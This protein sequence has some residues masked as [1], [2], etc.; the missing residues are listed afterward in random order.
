MMERLLNNKKGIALLIL[1][2]V[3]I[4]VIAISGSLAY[5][6][7]KDEVVNTF[8]MGKVQID[9]DE[10]GWNE[11]SG[12]NLL[13]GN[14]RVKDPIV[15]ALEGQ[16]YMRIRMEIVDG[17]GNLITDEN[18][19]NMILDTLYYDEAYGTEKA[20]IQNDKR[21][22]VAD[23]TALDNANKINKEYNRAAFTFAGTENGNPAV[24][25]Y[26]Y[27]ANN[28]IFNADNKDKAILFTNV[29]IP[30][31]WHNSEI[32]FLNGDTFE[33]NE[34]G[35]VEVIES[36]SGY[37]IRLKAQAIQSSEMANATEAFATLDKKVK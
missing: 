36:G 32:F 12:L 14:V 6:T 15:T 28:G 19:I 8:A 24:R 4:T 21:Y 31:D 1:S 7:D 29:I 33:T 20:S 37:K 18:R 27:I 35:G 30:Q 23:L 34:S 16:S 17:D 22:K 3:L 9:L 13:P 11:N 10:P 26:N 5:F 25:Y 2:V